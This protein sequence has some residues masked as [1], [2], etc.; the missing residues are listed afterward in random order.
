MTSMIRR[1]NNT[2]V[3]EV[4][5][6]LL[7][8]YQLRYHRNSQNLHSSSFPPRQR[9]MTVA[10]SKRH[11]PFVAS[12]VQKWT[13]HSRPRRTTRGFPWRILLIHQLKRRRPRSGI[14]RQVSLLRTGRQN[15]ATQPCYIGC[16]RETLSSTA[17]CSE[18][19]HNLH[20]LRCPPFS[21]PPVRH[22][23]VLL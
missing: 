6:T 3:R 20:S 5:Q 8:S 10:A 13:P 17:G 19:A 9:C 11:G 12:Q 1:T 7:P 15:L 22:I 23:R 18:E 21:R 14:L 16:W 2:T 4:L